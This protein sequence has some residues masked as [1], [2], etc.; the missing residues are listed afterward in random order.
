[1]ACYNACDGMHSSYV[2]RWLKARYHVWDRNENEG[3]KE[4]Y[5]SM[6]LKCLVGIKGK[7]LDQC[8]AVKPAV[9]VSEFQPK[10]TPSPLLIGAK[11]DYIRRGGECSW[12][13]FRWWKNSWAAS[14]FGRQVF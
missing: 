5:Y 14:I 7:A 6:V 13:L 3:Q 1:M 8:E 11:I 2:D 4:L 9:A 12:I 10:G